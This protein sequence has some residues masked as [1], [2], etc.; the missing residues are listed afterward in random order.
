MSVKI[1][2]AGRRYVQVEVEVPGT[3]EDVWQT[4]ATGP[5]VSAWFVPTDV[6]E[7]VGGRIVSHFAPGMDAVATVTAW[8]P[9]HRFAAE[10]EDYAPGAP[11]LATEWIVEARGG[12]TCVV[13]VVHS[14]FASTEEWDDQLEGTEAGWPTFFH[15]LRLYLEHFRGQ[16][17]ASVSLT[18]M[19]AGE[20]TQ[21][22]EDLMRALGLDATG[23]GERCATS[24][25]DVPG[26]AGIVEPLAEIPHGRR[27]LVRLDR[28][29]PGFAMLGAYRCSGTVMGAI[30]L[31]LYGEEADDV[32]ARDEPVWRAW[33]NRH[34]APA[35]A[36]GSAG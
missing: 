14:L 35:D 7:R 25:A 19:V 29:A 33:M 24:G 13:R 4:I 20:V 9:P 36:A 17:C 2:D 32:L 31:Y 12:G 6:E 10:S 34:F 18:G 3:P 11:T 16:R 21:V 27:I 26:L 22:W 23:A 15:I 28:P 5:G 30:S 8:D 1:D